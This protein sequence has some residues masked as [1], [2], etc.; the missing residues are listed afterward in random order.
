MVPKYFNH[1]NTYLPIWVIVL[2]WMNSWILPKWLVLFRYSIPT[3]GRSGLLRT[4]PEHI[5]T[6]FMSSRSGNLLLIIIST[7]LPCLG[8]IQNPGIGYFRFNTYIGGTTWWMCYIDFWNCFTRYSCFEVRESIADISTELTCL[9]D[10]GNLGQIPSD[11]RVTQRYKW[12]YLYTKDLYCYISTD[13]V[14]MYWFY[15]RNGNF[16]VTQLRNYSTTTEATMTTFTF[17]CKAIS[18]GSYLKKWTF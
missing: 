17:S 14:E 18:P 4:V 5:P 13:E 16:L 10:L 2:F 12:L 8:D 6:I 7:E 15:S 9:G 11:S 3:G 1:C